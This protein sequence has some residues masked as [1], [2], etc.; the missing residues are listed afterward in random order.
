MDYELQHNTWKFCVP[1]KEYEKITFS[2]LD[3]G[4]RLWWKIGI[5]IIMFNSLLCPFDS[6][7]HLF[8]AM[9]MMIIMWSYTIV[10]AT[11]I[12]LSLVV[13][14]T[15]QSVLWRMEIPS[16]K[17]LVPYHFV[18]VSISCLDGGGVEISLVF[19]SYLST[20]RSSDKPKDHSLY[21]SSI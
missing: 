11:L 12:S 8:T 17:R 21:F 1:Q 10:V 13:M 19:L 3:Q 15:V 6:F 14:L 18:D 16:G 5:L 4:S 2:Q 7:C 20:T 9:W